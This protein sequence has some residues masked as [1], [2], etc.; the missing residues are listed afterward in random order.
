MKLGILFVF[1]LAHLSQTALGADSFCSLA[2]SK[3]W[4]EMM[5]ETKQY[6]TERLSA[7]EAERAALDQEFEK[8]AAKSVTTVAGEDGKDLKN[9]IQAVRGMNEV[10]SHPDLVHALSRA[11]LKVVDLKGKGSNA[12]RIKKQLATL[13]PEQSFELGLNLAEELDSILES[14]RDSGLKE[15]I[16]NWQEA[17]PETLGVFLVSNL[18]RIAG[19]EPKLFN[20]GIS[21]VSEKVKSVLSSLASWS[22]GLL[23]SKKPI[24]DRRFEK[25]LE[26]GP[27]AAGRLRFVT[28]VQVGL[29][30]G[31]VAV[32]LNDL[33]STGF[34]NIFLQL[35]GPQLGSSMTKWAYAAAPEGSVKVDSKRLT[36]KR[37]SMW[38][39]VVLTQTVGVF[40][41]NIEWFSNLIFG[42][43]GA[44][45]VL[46]RSLTTRSLSVDKTAAADAIVESVYFVRLNQSQ[47]E[48]LLTVVSSDRQQLVRDRIKEIAS[49]K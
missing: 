47:L 4:P 42:P 41:P 14:S 34:Y 48:Q 17:Y 1:L 16:S 49:V 43:G 28:A 37:W 5:I 24:S 13:S 27:K 7:K 18:T 23:R 35:F 19:E 15:K 33:D 21:G 3:D 9:W 39:A 30:I 45:V 36:Q 20:K 26:L 25:L 22:T 12:E 40:L 2:L 8:L 44:G 31:S 46:G 11:S 29:A 32:M 6:F 10:R 38:G